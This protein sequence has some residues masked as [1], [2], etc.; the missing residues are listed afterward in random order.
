ML[1]SAS[2]LVKMIRGERH[3]KR[4]DLCP[5]RARRDR[6]LHRA[7]AAKRSVPRALVALSHRIGHLRRCPIDQHFKASFAQRSLRHAAHPER[8]RVDRL[9]RDPRA[10]NR[11][12]RARRRALGARLLDDYRGGLGRPSSHSRCADRCLRCHWSKARCIAH[13]YPAHVGDNARRAD[14]RRTPSGQSGGDTHRTL[15]K[16]AE[17]LASSTT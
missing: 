17:E 6:L 7:S 14:A 4:R 12:L 1:E 2:Q 10:N 8:T 3:R 15:S 16:Q 13:V 11:A 9:R 5:R